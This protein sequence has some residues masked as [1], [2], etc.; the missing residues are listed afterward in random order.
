MAAGAAL[1]ATAAGFRGVALAPAASASSLCSAA[2]C[3]SSWASFGSTS[4]FLTTISAPQSRRMLAPA[5][6]TALLAVQP[7]LHVQAGVQLLRGVSACE[8]GA[9]ATQTAGASAAAAASGATTSPSRFAEGR[10]GSSSR[11]TATSSTPFTWAPRSSPQLFPRHPT[12]TCQW[13][14]SPSGPSTRSSSPAPARS[15][16][17]FRR[18]CTRC[19]T[20][21]AFPSSPSMA[22]SAPRP[23]RR[24]HRRHSH[25]Q[26]LNR[27]S[28]QPQRRPQR[29]AKRQPRRGERLRRSAR[30]PLRQR[31]QPRPATLPSRHRLQGARGPPC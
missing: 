18:S 20:G 19:A 23:R 11:I 29:A 2:S 31:F 16:P 8:R 6:P 30:P 4:G 22:Q 28:Q 5:L 3:S 7:R 13:S 12:S 25:Q 26:Q 9:A 17:G 1:T 21:L 24:H 15:V 10:P 14:A 27:L